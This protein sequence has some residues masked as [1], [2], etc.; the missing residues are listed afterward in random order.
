[1][2]AA[3]KSSCFG[4]LQRLYHGSK[5]GIRGKIRPC[6]RDL[7]DFGKG[8]YMGTNK[9]QVLTLVCNFEHAVFYELGFN[10]DGLSVLYFNADIDWAMFVAYNRGRMENYKDTAFYRSLAE[11]KGAY[12][13]IVG[14]IADDRMYLVLDQFFDSQMTDSALVKCLSIL[15]LG[16]Q[17][18]A[19]NDKACGRVS[20]TSERVLDKE[21]RE[22]LS[23]ESDTNRK[24][25]ASEAD[26]IRREHRRDGRYFDELLEGML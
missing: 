14:P 7:C 21:E 23:A 4:D 25:A 1:M 10:T 13:V 17:W 19:M 22:R 24:Y 16:N 12:D 3:E 20:I 8:F 5:S 18:V 9:Q 26:K 11:R 6:S 2:K 15:N